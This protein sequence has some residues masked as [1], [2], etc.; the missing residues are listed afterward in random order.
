MGTSGQG[1]APGEGQGDGGLTQEQ[2]ELLE[3]GNEVFGGK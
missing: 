1:V 2:R 3:I